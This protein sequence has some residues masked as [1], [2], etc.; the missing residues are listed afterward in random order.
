M[1]YYPIG[2]N[3]PARVQGA[4]ISDEEL[5]QVIRFIRRQESPV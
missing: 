5:R 2:V 1:L 3:R 4:F